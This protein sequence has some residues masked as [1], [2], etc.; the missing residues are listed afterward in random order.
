MGSIVSGCYCLTVVCDALNNYTSIC[1][2]FMKDTF[3]VSETF[4]LVM[5]SVVNLL[6]LTL[7]VYT[8][9]LLG[10]FMSFFELLTVDKL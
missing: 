5:I 10:V 1:P 7:I 6:T 3:Y 4:I 8:A 2:I 9:I